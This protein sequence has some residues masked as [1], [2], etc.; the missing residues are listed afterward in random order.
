MFVSSCGH[1]LNPI[2][3]NIAYY[4]THSFLRHL[5]EQHHQNLAGKTC[6]TQ[7]TNVTCLASTN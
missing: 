6:C 5:N 2:E 3:P 7:P 1:R 4:L